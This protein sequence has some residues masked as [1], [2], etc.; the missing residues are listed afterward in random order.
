MKLFSLLPRYAD[1]TVI[2]EFNL[3]LLGISFVRGL[4]SPGQQLDRI[5][6]KLSFIYYKFSHGK[7]GLY[8]H[9][10]GRYGAVGKSKNSRVTNEYEL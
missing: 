3:V 4:S 10:F 8:D 9:K 6:Y 1:K 2:C 7:I 5:K